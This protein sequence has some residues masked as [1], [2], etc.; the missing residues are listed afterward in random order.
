MALRATFGK[1]HELNNV[2]C[3]HSFKL[4]C[5]PES[6]SFLKG[7]I[8]THTHTHTIKCVVVPAKKKKKKVVKDLLSF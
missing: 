4:Y 5:F 2:Y 1:T 6:F 3:I 7:K 8:H